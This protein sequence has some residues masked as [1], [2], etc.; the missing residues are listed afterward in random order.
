MN[1][2][3]KKKWFMVFVNYFLLFRL[4]RANTEKEIFTAN[5]V[6]VPKSIIEEIGGQLINEDL[7]TL[8]PPYTIQRYEK[9]IPFRN[10]EEFSLTGE[11][12]EKENWYILD[13]L[14]GG[15]TYEARI[16]YAA[17]SPS[18]FILEIMGL[19][20]AARILNKQKGLQNNGSNFEPQEKVS[21]TKKLVRVRAIHEGVSVIP[22][23]DSQ[24][25]IYNIVLETLLFG[26]PRVAFKLILVLGVVM[27]LIYFILVPM[28]YKSLQKVIVGDEK[29][30]EE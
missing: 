29:D 15:H 6:K 17:T 23:K 14:E 24:P 9:I 11:N 7:V 22:G 2:W 4:I 13:G 19:E 8:I 10:D 28:I 18:I 21:T 26:V 5:T 16:S 12:G 20:E 1:F 3:F 30:H 27:G 25:V